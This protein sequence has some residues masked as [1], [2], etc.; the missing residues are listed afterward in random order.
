M[1]EARRTVRTRTVS[2]RYYGA[3]YGNYGYESAVGG[4]FRAAAYAVAE[5]LVGKSRVAGK[6]LVDASDSLFGR[7]YIGVDYEY[8]EEFAEP[9]VEGAPR[10]S[11]ESIDDEEEDVR[12]VDGSLCDS[13]DRAFVEG[14]RV[15]S[16]SAQRFADELDAERADRRRRRRVRVVREGVQRTRVQREETVKTESKTTPR[17]SGTPEQPK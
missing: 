2:S 6:L 12:V 1:P 4:F 13:F 11:A 9:D 17:Q 8:D 5:I 16:R 15:F 14:S 3:P 10:E 7:R